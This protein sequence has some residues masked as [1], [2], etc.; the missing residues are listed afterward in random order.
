MRTFLAVQER[1]QLHA[2]TRKGSLFVLKKIL[3]IGKQ[4][5]SGLKTAKDKELYFEDKNELV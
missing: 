4:A 5:A 1:Q 2:I 3:I